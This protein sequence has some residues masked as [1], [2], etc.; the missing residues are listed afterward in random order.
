MEVFSSAL[1]VVAL[2]AAGAVI[3]IFDAGLDTME[4]LHELM[5]TSL[6]A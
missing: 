2:S 4:R 1:L 3:L 5:A 6:A